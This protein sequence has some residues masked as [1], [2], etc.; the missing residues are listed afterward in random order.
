MIAFQANLLKCWKIYKFMFFLVYAVLCFANQEEST[1]E[2]QLRP[3]PFL[4]IDP[5]DHVEN[6]CKIKKGQEALGYKYNKF[7][8][9]ITNTINKR[10]MVQ[11]AKPGNHIST[12]TRQGKFW[13]S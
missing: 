3:P 7:N 2:H 4:T 5:L 13:L 8:K 12:I 1:M 11:E 10:K 9:Q 6:G